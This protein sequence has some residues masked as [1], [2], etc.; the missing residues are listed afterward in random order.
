MRRT[1]TPPGVQPG[2]GI[3]LAHKDDRGGKV[4][5]PALR[6]NIGARAG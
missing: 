6:F 4:A 5:D 3:G 1:K 2:G